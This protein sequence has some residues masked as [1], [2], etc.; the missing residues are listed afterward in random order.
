M[1]TVLDDSV[2]SYLGIRMASVLWSFINNIRHQG[3]SGVCGVAEEMPCHSE[4]DELPSCRGRGHRASQINSRHF[5]GATRT[6]P[7]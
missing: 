2:K 6:F 1:F 4:D 3:R 7:V 5:C